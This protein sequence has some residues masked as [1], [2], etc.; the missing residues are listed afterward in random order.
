MLVAF[1][2][3]QECSQV[4]YITTRPG[5]GRARPRQRG[6][7]GLQARGSTWVVPTLIVLLVAGATMVGSGKLG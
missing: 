4:R 1:A 7:G 2:S 3:P 6:S 5:S